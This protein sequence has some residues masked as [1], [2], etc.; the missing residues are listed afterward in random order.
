MNHAG[1]TSMTRYFG[2]NRGKAISV[3]NL[4]GM[5]GVMFLPFLIVYLSDYFSFKQIWLFCGL[6]LLFFL[7]ILFFILNNQF[8]RQEKFK[9]SLI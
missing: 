7:P 4:G 1:I 8:K 5:T 9:N 2:K 3:G 6:S